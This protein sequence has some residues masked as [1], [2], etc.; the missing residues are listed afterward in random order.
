MLNKRI[1]ELEHEVS[2][3]VDFN[4]KVQTSSRE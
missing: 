1:A 3:N 4:Q 2:Q